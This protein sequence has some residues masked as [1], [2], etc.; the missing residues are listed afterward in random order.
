[1]KTSWKGSKK[2]KKE[3]QSNKAFSFV[4]IPNYLIDKPE[5]LALVT[6]GTS[7]VYFSAHHFLFE[8][9][10]M[11][12]WEESTRARNVDKSFGL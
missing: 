10:S 6:R 3:N 7:P 5:L 12:N 8:V 1:M 4:T 11:I 2:K 9:E